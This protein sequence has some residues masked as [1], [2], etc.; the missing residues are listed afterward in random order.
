[1]KAAEL[2]RVGVTASRTREIEI[3]SVDLL[4]L[5][6]YARNGLPIVRMST[7]VSEQPADCA[8]IDYSIHSPEL[9]A[10]V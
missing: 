10:T 9:T 3:T 5:C 1:M 8:R 2:I 7:P 4:M 6:F